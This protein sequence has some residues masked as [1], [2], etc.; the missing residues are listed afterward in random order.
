V[1]FLIYFNLG[2]KFYTFNITTYYEPS[3]TPLH[4]SPLDLLSTL[5]SAISA[6]DISQGRKE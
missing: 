1:L 5:G 2:Y 4:Y 3:E 6:V